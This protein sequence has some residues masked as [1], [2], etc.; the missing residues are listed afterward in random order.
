[1]CPTRAGGGNMLWLIFV[2]SVYGFAGPPIWL[3]NTPSTSMAETIMIG[4]VYTADTDIYAHRDP[5]RGEVALFHPHADD[6]TVYVKR[7]IGLPG[8][9]VQMV[10]GTLVLNGTPVGREPG[11]KGPIAE[12][13]ADA[14]RYIETLPN[15]VR[16]E[17]LD[18]E[19]GGFLDNTRVF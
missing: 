8:D 7:V 9:R 13:P 16:Y 4:D 17:T 1:M 6:A 19:E 18:F 14:H 3:Y 2:A 11:A 5:E 12:A 15:G 10:D